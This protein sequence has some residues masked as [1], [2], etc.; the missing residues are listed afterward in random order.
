M[1]ILVVSDN[2]GDV[3]V[4]KKIIEENKDVDMVMHCGDLEASEKGLPHMEIVK[5][6]NDFYGFFE[7][8]K[9]FELEGHRILLIHGHQFSYFRRLESML[10]K[11]QEL[12]C[13]IVCYGHTHVASADEVEGKLFLNPGSCWRSRDGKAPSYA[14]LEITPDSKKYEIIRI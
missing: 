9:I 6:N 7:Q 11:S 14:I 8:Q 5:G 10:A 4:L 3:D 2:H 1:K 13:D 12:D